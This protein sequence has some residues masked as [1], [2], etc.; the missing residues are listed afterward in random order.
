MKLI[1]LSRSS[2]SKLWSKFPEDWQAKHCL[3]SLSTLLHCLDS[4]ISTHFMKPTGLAKGGYQNTSHENSP[5]K[6]THI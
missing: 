5:V 4:L 2:E 6:A 3:N 1:M